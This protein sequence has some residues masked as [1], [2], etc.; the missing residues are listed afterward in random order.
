MRYHELFL[1]LTA[2]H[3]LC[4]YL[5]HNPVTADGLSHLNLLAFPEAFWASY[6]SGT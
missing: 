1:R 4:P 5:G 3:E 6:R 2:V